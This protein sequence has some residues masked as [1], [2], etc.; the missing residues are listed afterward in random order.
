M[1]LRRS[2]A[3][4]ARVNVTS[5]QVR[6]RV[7]LFL[8]FDGTLCTTDTMHLLGRVPDAR[9]VRR[10]QSDRTSL[11]QHKL[12]SSADTWKL[13][14]ESYM[15]D[16]T[17]YQS[18]NLPGEP[19]HAAYSRYLAGLRDIEM[20][21]VHRVRAAGFFA[22]IDEPDVVTVAKTAILSGEI[23]FSSGSAELFDM[24]D[25]KGANSLP[26]GSEVAILSVNWS[27]V[28]IRSLVSGMTT[29]AD[30]RHIREEGSYGED[31]SG[32]CALQRP[33]W[34]TVANEIEELRS[35]EK[36]NPSSMLEIRT[37]PDKLREMQSMLAARQNPSLV[38]YVGDS[39]T[40]YECLRAADIG[41]WLC[42]VPET[43]F[44]RQYLRV[45]MP[46]EDIPVPIGQSRAHS[47]NASWLWAQ[48]LGQV[49]RYLREG[50]SGDE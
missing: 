38:V 34:T 40:D 39:A 3:A 23:Q 2:A 28:L 7:H 41:I 31:S 37:A 26:C 35:A 43:K 33:K 25:E 47:G 45:F 20:R 8:D 18:T 30:E 50:Y 49:A 36:G 15:K 6:P 24:F 44:K 17:V 14:G 22:G 27:A 9:D 21:S 1:S 10:C 29:P 5:M 13:F 32:E 12:A 42:N 19:D 46:L 11:T 48:N 16:Y 4:L